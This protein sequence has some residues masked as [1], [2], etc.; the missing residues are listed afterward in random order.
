MSSIQV[1]FYSAAK[2]SS[3]YRPNIMRC[4]RGKGG[5][6]G[7]L[8]NEQGVV[9]EWSAANATTYPTMLHPAQRYPG[10]GEAPDTPGKDGPDRKCPPGLFCATL[11]LLAPLTLRERPKAHDEV[12]SSAW[13][14]RS[15]TAVSSMIGIRGRQAT[16]TAARGE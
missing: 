4:A 7:D 2:L 16:S 12:R 14:V 5:G 13:R 15:T 3:S 1:R 6:S 10:A 8:G 11:R 9:S